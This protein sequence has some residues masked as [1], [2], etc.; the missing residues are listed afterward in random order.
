KD[1]NINSKKR[2]V[3]EKVDIKK[4][5][6]IKIIQS[7]IDSDN[8]SLLEKALQLKAPAITTA[9]KGAKKRKLEEFAKEINELLEKPTFIEAEQNNLLQDLCVMLNKK[10]SKDQLIMEMFHST[11]NY[12]REFCVHGTKTDCKKN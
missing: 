5:G 2:L 12:F 11:N 9:T 8:P 1:K 6:V 10:S 4:L 3:V 7:A